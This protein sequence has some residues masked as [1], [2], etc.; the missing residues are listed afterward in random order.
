MKK[1]LIPLLLLSI[2]FCN[3]CTTIIKT[4]AKSAANNY[5]DHL[6]FQN[7][8]LILEDQSGK[9]ASFAEL[10]PGKA[11]YMY[12]WKSPILLPPDD[13]EPKYAGLK[14]RFEKYD[15][16]VFIN[17]YT[18][19]KEEDWKLID[20]LKQSRVK[21]YRLTAA[22]ANNAFRELYEVSTSPQIIGKNGHTLGFKGPKPSDELVVDYALFGARTG[23]NA[24]ESIN[25][26]IK[27][28]DKDQ[29]F[30]SEELKT[31]YR[32]HFG[33]DPEQKIS[34]TISSNEDK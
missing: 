21:S 10:F 27:N 16:V 4:M 34:A 32:D 7:N 22:P 8:G 28:V 31:W 9:T 12:I 23:K 15:D 20:S 18:G 14:S 29:R 11:V 3:S 17:V 2:L 30:K 25:V 26:L 19:N 5:N 33:K 1:S 13:R 24:T 6:D